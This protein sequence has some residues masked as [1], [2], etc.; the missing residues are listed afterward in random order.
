MFLVKNQNKYEDIFVPSLFTGL[1]IS[2]LKG[3]RHEWQDREN[4]PP[5]CTFASRTILLPLL[6]HLF[7]RQ[8]Y[9]CLRSKVKRLP[10]KEC[11]SLRSELRQSNK[12]ISIGGAKLRGSSEIEIYFFL[13]KPPAFFSLSFTVIHCQCHN[14]S[15]LKLVNVFIFRDK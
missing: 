14:L 3:K 10:C 4:S 7:P 1:L 5:L 2:E 15:L 6:G 13:S 8:K 11:N 12:A 9:T